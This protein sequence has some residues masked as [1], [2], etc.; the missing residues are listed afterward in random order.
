MGVAHGIQL[1]VFP[2]QTERTLSNAF[3]YMR[4][5][6]AL[7]VGQF[8]ERDD[9]HPA[10]A[11]VK[12]RPRVPARTHHAALTTHNPQRDKIRAEI[13]ITGDMAIASHSV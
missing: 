1:V 10:R 3:P 7:T 9:R 6:R 5:E 8:P 11:M 12:G 13:R 4:A 2:D